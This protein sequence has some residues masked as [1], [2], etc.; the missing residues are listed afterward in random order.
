MIN[1]D[2]L[3]SKIFFRD[4]QLYQ[5]YFRRFY[6]NPKKYINKYLCI[7]EYLNNRYNDSKDIRETLYRIYRN[8][9]IRPVCKIC[10]KELN[11]CIV[12]KKNQ[13]FPTYCSISCE[14]KDPE[15]MKKH[16]DSCIE[17]YGSVNNSKKTK[18]TCLERYGVKAGFNNGKE[19]IT[20]LLKYGSEIYVNPQKA[21]ETCIKKYG[22]ISPLCLN[23]TRIKRKSFESLQKEYN[24]KRKNN[25]FNTS[26][27]E[28][29]S[30]ELLKQKYPDTIRQYRSD[31]YPFN[32]DFYIPSL[33]LYIECNYSW[34]HGGHPFNKDN[35]EDLKLL[36]KWKSGKSNYYNNAI[37]TWT[38]RDVNKRNIAKKNR[39]NWVEFF[40]VD[41]FGFWLTHDNLYIDYNKDHIK[42]EYNYYLNE[43][44]KLSKHY[45]NSYIV[46]YFQQ[47]ILYKKEFDL[48]DNYIIRKKLIDNRI[49]YLDKQVNEISN[50][51]FIDGFK[52]SMIYY[53][54]SHF[55]PLWFKWFIERYDIKR[56]YDPC[57]GWG[58]RLLGSG[59]L[60]LYIY[61][62]LSHTVYDNI[63]KMIDYLN[64][65]NCITYNNDANNFIPTEDFDS[66]FTCPPYY[67]L[68]HYECGD[69]KSIDEY[70]K[71]TDNLFNCFYNKP[72]CKIF[73]LVIREDLLEDKW[74]DKSVDSFLV[75]NRKAHHIVKKQKNNN[76]YL[77]I[78]AK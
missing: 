30:Y 63:N 21:R 67:N 41:D 73:G 56:C 64:I 55:N 26:K 46:K 3:I 8:I 11:L 43:S 68:E 28:E 9:E 17:K 12:N 61:N 75:N 2:K 58:H 29:Q 22:V 76:E 33:D 59:K 34:T 77:Y 27:P 60:D 44:G 78:F 32:C 5:V 69:F 31:L 51:E 48:W 72:N 47:D 54:Y 16:N 6:K 42:N 7:K 24:T 20:K 25:S 57:G 50:M 4:N 10:G 14:M 53:G 36:E 71:F 70:N 23:T 15:V 18:N 66:M 13:V 37:T 40:N 74:K 62:D 65:K 38:I 1:H 19:K 45:T 52:R 49:K 35:S 39:L